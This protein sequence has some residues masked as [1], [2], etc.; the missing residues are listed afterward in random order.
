[1]SDNLLQL[2]VY[3]RLNTISLYR[4]YYNVRQERFFGLPKLVDV[5]SPTTLSQDM[6]LR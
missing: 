1:M 6:E 2:E 5:A 4:Q 3:D